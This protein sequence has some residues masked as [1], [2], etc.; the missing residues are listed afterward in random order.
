[1]TKDIFMTPQMIECFLLK[2]KTDYSKCKNCDRDA[3]TEFV[4]IIDS[5]LK[6]GDTIHIVFTPQHP[7][8]R[9]QFSNLTSIS[10]PTI[11]TGIL[12]E[13]DE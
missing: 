5:G 8:Y 2:Q 7:I 13:G 6:P 9:I 4:D 12:K 3:C 10:S 1:M 11:T